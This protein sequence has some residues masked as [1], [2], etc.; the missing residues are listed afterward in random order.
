MTPFGPLGTPEGF[1]KKFLYSA[2]LDIKIHFVAKFQENLM[3]GYP[4]IS[5][6]HGGTDGRTDGT[7]YYSPFPT[8]VGGL[9]R[10]TSVGVGTCDKWYR[11][12]TPTHRVLST[13][14]P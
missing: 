9:K 3:D 4:A 1:L 2:Q 13:V 14:K 11:V 12:A 6:T 10:N 5:R 7:D 8:K